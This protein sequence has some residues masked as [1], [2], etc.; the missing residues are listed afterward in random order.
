LG[1]SIQVVFKDRVAFTCGTLP[2]I[3]VIIFLIVLM[4]VILGIDP[5]QYGGT[6]KAQ[7]L[8]R[9]GLIKTM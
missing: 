4:R 7:S 2:F 3:G 9:S 6:K 1:F 8:M 5:S